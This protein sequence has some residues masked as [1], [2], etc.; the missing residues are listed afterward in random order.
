MTKSAAVKER[1]FRSSLWPIPWY[2]VPLCGQMVKANRS[3]LRTDRGRYLLSFAVSNNGTVHGS[4]RPEINYAALTRDV[5]NEV[6]EDSRR[7]KVP[8]QE[9]SGGKT[10]TAVHWLDDMN[11]RGA[12]LAAFWDLAAGFAK[13][14]RKP[15]NF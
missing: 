6:S 12:Q 8:S 15:F 14:T 11:V 7:T 4:S 1:F 13:A 10:P 5:I 9:T 3:A 2:W